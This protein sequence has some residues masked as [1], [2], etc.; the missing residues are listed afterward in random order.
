LLPVVVPVACLTIYLLLLVPN[1]RTYIGQEE[2]RENPLVALSPLYALERYVP[3]VT[4]PPSPTVAAPSPTPI[5]SSSLPSGPKETGAPTASIPTTVAVTSEERVAA[6]IEE[7]YVRRLDC[8]DLIQRI[9]PSLARSGY[10]LGAAWRVPAFIALTQFVAP[11]A[12]DEYKRTAR[13]TAKSYLLE[14]HTDLDPG[15]YYSCALTDLF[16]N[17]G[18]AGFPVG[19]GLLALAFVMTRRV[20]SGGVPIL[21]NH[22]YWIG[23]VLAAHLIPFEQ[24]FSTYLFGWI[25]YLPAAL[26]LLLINPVTKAGTRPAPIYR[27]GGLLRRGSP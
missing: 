6:Y 27:I 13:T 11:S 12:S 21:G 15:D 24:E 9:E 26:A 5:A 1:V 14:R 19:A 16:G 25:R 18:V 23:L 4:R 17:F 2:P 22:V 10:E 7:G 8:I 20:M 3:A